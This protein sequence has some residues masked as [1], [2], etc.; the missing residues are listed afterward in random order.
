MSKRNERPLAL[1]TFVQGM[2]VAALVL[3]GGLLAMFAVGFVSDLI[4]H[5]EMLVSDLD[6]PWIFMQ[7]LCCMGVGG[8]VLWLLTEFVAMCGRVKRKTAFTEKNVR[9]LGRIVMAFAIA[10]VLLLPCGGLLIGFLRLGLPGADRLI[11]PLL[12]TGA[13]WAA[14][15]LV[16]AIQVLMRRAEELQSVQDLTI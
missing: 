3:L 14:A 10:G 12:P 7:L 2:G 16:R 8:C 4:H 6:F 15:L 9:A 5:G 1:I 11:L 13:A